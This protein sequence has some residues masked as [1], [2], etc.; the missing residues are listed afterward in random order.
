[1]SQ[2]KIIISHFFNRRIK[3]ELIQYQTQPDQQMLSL[4]M[5]ITL[6]FNPQNSSHKSNKKKVMRIHLE[7][8]QFFFFLMYMDDNNI[9][10]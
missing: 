7:L 8:L 1:M 6:D 4:T 2:L 10:V 5:E 9:P 3:M